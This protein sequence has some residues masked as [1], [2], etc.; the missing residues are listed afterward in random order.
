M[1]DYYYFQDKDDEW[2]FTPVLGEDYI[3]ALKS[4]A[5][6]YGVKITNK[7]V[8]KEIYGEQVISKKPKSKLKRGKVG[9]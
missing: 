4:I 7:M 5:K 8:L 9:R 6:K 1:S 2:G 3:H